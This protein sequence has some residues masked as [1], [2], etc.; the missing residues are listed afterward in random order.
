MKA[1][2]VADPCYFAVALAVFDGA[3]TFPAASAAFTW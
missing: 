2:V 1:I 3:E